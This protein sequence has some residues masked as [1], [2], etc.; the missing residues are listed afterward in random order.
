[1]K[2]RWKLARR[3]SFII[4]SCD[5]SRLDNE[6]I[7]KIP[8]VFVEII[9]VTLCVEIKSCS[10]DWNATSL[11]LTK[12][13]SERDCGCLETAKTT[14]S[15]SNAKARSVVG[16]IWKLNKRL[17]WKRVKEQWQSNSRGSETL[18]FNRCFRRTKADYYEVICQCYF[19]FIWQK[20][21]ILK[22]LTYAYLTSG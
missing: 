1:M 6:G 14:L 16:L 8:F 22:Y 2:N 17:K 5:K 12:Y 3:A 21:N 19:N 11:Q 7:A 20:L 4:I 13:Y 10:S 15:I 9:S 18:K